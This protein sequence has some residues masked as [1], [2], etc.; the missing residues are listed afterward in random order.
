[1]SPSIP[2][3]HLI[4]TNTIVSIREDA[5]RGRFP[6]KRETNGVSVEMTFQMTE[7]SDNAFMLGK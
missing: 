2:V 3:V 1:M 6:R 4:S 7:L 5:Q